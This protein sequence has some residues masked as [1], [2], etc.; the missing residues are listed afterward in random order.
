M[1]IAILVRLLP[2]PF[3]RPGRDEQRLAIRKEDLRRRL[4]GFVHLARMHKK[5]T[6]RRGALK[7][8][9]LPMASSA[10]HGIMHE[11]MQQAGSGYTTC[12]NADAQQRAMSGAMYPR[13]LQ[14]VN[15]RE[16]GGAA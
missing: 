11:S 4:S 10:A 8:F 13:T 15:R 16:K 1:R 5:A 2:A 12:G 6:R 7:E 14:G 9:T 3:A